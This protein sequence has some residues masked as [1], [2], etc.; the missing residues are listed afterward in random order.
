MTTL[1]TG[2]IGSAL[3]AAV[4]RVTDSLHPSVQQIPV[5]DLLPDIDWTP[6]HPQNTQ[7]NQLA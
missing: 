7:P 2:F 3:T 4:R 6:A 5:G 1:L